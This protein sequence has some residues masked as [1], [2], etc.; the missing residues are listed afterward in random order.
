MNVAEK[1]PQGTVK[2]PKRVGETKRK[3][4]ERGSGS[5][6][7]GE[8]GR[9]GCTI[10]NGANRVPKLGIRFLLPSSAQ[11]NNSMSQIATLFLIL[12]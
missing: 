11:E 5:K 6:R 8:R 3:Q 4:G 1:S 7:K 12:D 10:A 2:N 9:G